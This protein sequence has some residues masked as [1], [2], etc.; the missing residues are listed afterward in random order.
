MKPQRAK[1]DDFTPSQQTGWLTF[2]ML[3]LRASPSLDASLRAPEAKLE[4]SHLGTLIGKWKT[5]GEVKPAPA[6]ARAAVIPGSCE[7]TSSKFA[8]LCREG[9]VTSGMDETPE[10]VIYGY[11]IRTKKYVWTHADKRGEMWAGRG[12]YTGDSW[13]WTSDGMSQGKTLIFCF[14]EGWAAPDS[15]A[16]E[17]ANGLTVDSMVVMIDGK[18]TGVSTSDS[19]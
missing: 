7:S 6:G 19:R 13:T 14:A 17:N 18:Q 3:V 5:V 1:A 10:V 15:F 11:D 2:N 4:I 12:T 9:T 8:I 16:F